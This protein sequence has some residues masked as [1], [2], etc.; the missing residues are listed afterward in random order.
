MIYL[1]LR[2]KKK[3]NFKKSFNEGMD[4]EKFVVFSL[5]GRN[6][7]CV[8]YGSIYFSL[9]TLYITNNNNDDDDDNNNE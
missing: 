5:R 9:P 1:W 7:A 2:K 6:Y 8:I 3:R 4:V